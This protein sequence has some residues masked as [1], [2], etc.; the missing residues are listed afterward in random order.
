MTAGVICDGCCRIA[1]DRS[2]AEDPY[3]G[4]WE[5]EQYAAELGDDHED[6]EDS[7]ASEAELHFCSLRCLASW[8]TSKLV[9]PAEA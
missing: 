1:T 7:E 2:E 3:A 5:L 6:D 9:T 8:A 4:W